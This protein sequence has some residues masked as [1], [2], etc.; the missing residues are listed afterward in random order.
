[1]AQGPYQSPQVPPGTPGYVP[2]PQ[3]GGTTGLAIAAGVLM[4]VVS[5]VDLVG[6]YFYALGGAAISGVGAAA[7]QGEFGIVADDAQ[8]DVAAA[9]STGT[10]MQILGY[11][12]MIM[13]GLG[14]A[15]AILLFMG[16]AAMFVLGVGVLQF[17][18]DGASCAMLSHVGVMNILGFIT[19]ILVILGALSI[20][21]RQA[22]VA[23][24][25]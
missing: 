16:K 3:S 15:A 20:S 17:I 6:G 24:A 21:K 19:A 10:S 12:L 4:I 9:Q 11:F 8:A 13:F 2:L 7:E 22:Q 5:L 1:M 14:I 25:M 23:P 18:A